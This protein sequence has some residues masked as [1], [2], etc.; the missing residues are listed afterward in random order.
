MS[1]LLLTVKP[2]CQRVDWMQDSGEPVSDDEDSESELD[3]E[4]ALRFY[5]EVEERA[6]L[7]RKSKEP[8]AVE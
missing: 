5:R 1:Q 3:E 2:K 7:K 8:E 6:K 4:A